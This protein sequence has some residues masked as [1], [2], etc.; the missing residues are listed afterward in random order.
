MN[1]IHP[2]KPANI[3]AFPVKVSVPGLTIDISY[4]MTPVTNTVS[5]SPHSNNATAHAMRIR[6]PSLCLKHSQAPKMH[7]IAMQAFKIGQNHR[8]VSWLGI[9]LPVT[10]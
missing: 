9:N 3:I 4:K 1:N 10:Q 6:L 5:N 8:S 7:S 2:N